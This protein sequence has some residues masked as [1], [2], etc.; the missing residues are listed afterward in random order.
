MSLLVLASLTSGLVLPTPVPRAVAHAAPRACVL[1]SAER[2]EWFDTGSDSSAKNYFK[3]AIDR[4]KK[5]V[6]PRYYTGATDRPEDLHGV[7]ADG[8][9]V[10][11]ER[12]KID[13]G[14]TWKGRAYSYYK[15][16]FKTKDAPRDDVEAPQ[17]YTGQFDGVDSRGRSKSD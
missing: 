17:Y 16:F 2:E 5:K 10:T 13:S 6:I 15:S 1:L 3:A 14:M 12:A 4:A 9:P 8:R 7:A 11:K